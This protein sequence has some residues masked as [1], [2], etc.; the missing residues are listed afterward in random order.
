MPKVTTLGWLFE[1]ADMR[2]AC[3]GLLV[4]AFAAVFLFRPSRRGS[5]TTAFL[6]LIPGV[7]GMLL[8]YSASKEF[9]EMGRW[10]APPKPSEFA[11]AAGIG[12]GT[13]LFSLL[14]MCIALYVSLLALY[15][16]TKQLPLKDKRKTPLGTGIY[17]GRTTKGLNAYA[18][19]QGSPETHQV[20]DLH[21]RYVAG[22][23]NS[24][25]PNANQY[26]RN[27]TPPARRF[28]VEVIEQNHEPAENAQVEDEEIIDVETL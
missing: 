14:G 12:L 7:F 26:Q 13:G 15:R 25:S 16:S 1:N 24:E 8:V 22:S 4:A 19:P 11:E 28:D 9:T 18:P 5:Y 27:P 6:S 10:G 2:P 20:T 17:Q 21:M 23:A 3:L